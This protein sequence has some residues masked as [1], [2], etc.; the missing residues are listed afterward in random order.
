MLSNPQRLLG[1]HTTLSTFFCR[2]SRFDFHDVTAVLVAVMFKDVR[3]SRQPIAALFRAFCEIS[4]IPLTLRSSTN[5]A[6]YSVVLIEDACNSR[7][8]CI[9]ALLAP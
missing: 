1:F 2:A 5:T 9:P 7:G 4:G 6:S 8:R 3:K